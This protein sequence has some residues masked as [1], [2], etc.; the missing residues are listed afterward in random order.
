MISDG[1][2][3]SDKLGREDLAFVPEQ[4]AFDSLLAVGSEM[5][6]APNKDG[7]A[8]VGPQDNVL[9]GTDD[10]RLLWSLVDA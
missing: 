4:R 6:A 10:L 3:L 8:V 1:V 9:A 7:I 2:S 5:G